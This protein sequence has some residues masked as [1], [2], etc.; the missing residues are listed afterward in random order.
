MQLNKHEIHIIHINNK[1]EHKYN[2][3]HASII[4]NHQKVYHCAHALDLPTTSTK[5]VGMH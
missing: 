2:M 5:L 3:V 4:F 1:L